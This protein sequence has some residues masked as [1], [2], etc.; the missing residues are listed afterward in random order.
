MQTKGKLEY[1]DFGDWEGCIRHIYGM[2]WGYRRS[3]K[4]SSWCISNLRNYC[5]I[6]IS[7]STLI[8][9]CHIIISLTSA[10]YVVMC[11]ACLHTEVSQYMIRKTNNAVSVWALD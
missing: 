5:G 9:R 7:H 1:A 10:G 6:I 11:I 3:L 8:L 2:F 4:G